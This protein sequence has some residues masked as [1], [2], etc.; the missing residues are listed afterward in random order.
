MAAKAMTQPKLAEQA[1][2][3]RT[4]AIDAPGKSMG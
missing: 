3:S 2:R 1:S 4:V